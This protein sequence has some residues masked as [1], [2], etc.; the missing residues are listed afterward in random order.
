MDAEKIA[1][2]DSLTARSMNSNE[3]RTSTRPS[4]QFGIQ[5]PY[6]QEEPRGFFRRFC[7][8]FTADPSAHATPA[9]AVKADGGV[10]DPENPASL[11]DGGNTAPL[12]KELKK[13]HLQMIAIGGCIGTGLFIGSGKALVGAS[14]IYVL[15]KS[16]L[17][18]CTGSRGHG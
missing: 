17:M 6:R 8:S 7:T 9:G 13:R 10:F 11:A 3:L 2:N 12:Q 14:M 4:Q 1:K 16:I 5:E 15:N 18:H